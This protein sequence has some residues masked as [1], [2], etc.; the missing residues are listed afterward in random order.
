MGN[1]LRGML[2]QGQLDVK[3]LL[4]E[5]QQQLPLILEIDQLKLLTGQD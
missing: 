1:P 3:G 2:R 4:L 5:Q